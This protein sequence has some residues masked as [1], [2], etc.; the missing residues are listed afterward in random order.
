[1]IFQSYL[2]QSWPL[3]DGRGDEALWGA[4]VKD[5]PVNINQ[6]YPNHWVYRSF[7]FY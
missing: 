2:K 3:K 6:G 4:E 7:E 1:M 5:T